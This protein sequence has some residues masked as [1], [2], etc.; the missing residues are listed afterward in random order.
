LDIALSRRVTGIRILLGTPFQINTAEG[1]L[2]YSRRVAEVDSAAELKTPGF[3]SGSSIH[4]QA[5]FPVISSHGE[6]SGFLRALLT[7]H[8]ISWYD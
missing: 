6:R 8:V 7:R 3:W 4:G 2:R 1:I 5:W